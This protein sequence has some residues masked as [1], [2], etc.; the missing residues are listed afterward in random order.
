MCHEMWSRRL[1]ERAQEEGRQVWDLF[2]RETREEPPQPVADKER[3]DEEREPV[4][5]EPARR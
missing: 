1:R 3:P 2:D 5:T 4:M